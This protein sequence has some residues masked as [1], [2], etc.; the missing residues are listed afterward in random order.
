MIYYVII[1]NIVHVFSVHVWYDLINNIVM[2]Y[3]LL[4]LMVIESLKT[5]ADHVAYLKHN[6]KAKYE[7]ISDATLHKNNTLT[8][9]KEMLK[10][11]NDEAA[12]A[13]AAAEAAT[14]AA[15]TTTTTATTTI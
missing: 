10:S 2:A 1:D 4:R 12:T 14:V 11:A 3:V 8:K 7:A 5:K 6:F 13:A 9:L 15:A